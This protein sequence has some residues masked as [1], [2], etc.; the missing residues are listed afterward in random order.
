MSTR[1]RESLAATIIVALESHAV[2][3]R[4]AREQAYL[5]SDRPFLGVTVPT[6]RAVVRAALAD[7]GFAVRKGA[8]VGPVGRDEALGAANA[9]WADERFDCRR[10]AVEVLRLG[11]PLLTSADLSWL[12]D[13]VRDGESWAIV[14]ELSV[15][16]IGP[17]VAREPLECGSVLDAWAADPDS[18]WVR[19]ASM[20]C[21]L[22]PLRNGGGDWERFCRYADQMLGERE[23]FIR[24]AI[25]WILRDTSRRRPELVADWVRP[26]LDR[27][28]GVTRREA[29]KY[30][31]GFL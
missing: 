4:A 27:M 19:R 3:G 21:L 1:P 8:V 7:C 12:G 30:L 11:S 18:F 20:L 23:F 16:V 5:K 24:K 22:E 2:P 28:S 26:R 10:A 29:V 14:D 31:G 13:W 15:R 17:I 6:N 9:L 25:G